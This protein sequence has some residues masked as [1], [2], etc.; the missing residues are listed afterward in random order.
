MKEFDAFVFLAVFQEM[1]GW[2][3]WALLAIA[4]I[5]IAS[6]IYVVI[7]DRG[8]RMGRFVAAQLAGVLTGFAAVF[9]MWWITSSSIMDVG[10]PIDVIL[11][12]AIW[13]GGFIG[14]T[15]LGYGLIGL[16]PNYQRVDR[17]IRSPGL[18]VST[19]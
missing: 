15:V 17:K 7:R 4:A 5:G 19:S 1:L 16:A 12:L 8:M 6:F 9:F 18:E 10:G 13:T 3:L 11:L 14:G 2:W